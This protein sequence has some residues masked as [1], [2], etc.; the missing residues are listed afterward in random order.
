M[1]VSDHIFDPETSSVS[2]LTR[3]AGDLLSLAYRR[4]DP[5]EIFNQSSAWRVALDQKGKASSADMHFIGLLGE[6]AAAVFLG[7]A[8]V[9]EEI[10]GGDGGRGDL[11]L[12][13]GKMVQVKTRAWQG[14]DFALG[15]ESPA[16]FQADYGI[17]VWPGSQEVAQAMRHCGD[18]TA[19]ALLTL[20]LRSELILSIAGVITREDF[21]SRFQ[22]K[23]LGYGTRAVV[24]WHDMQRPEDWL[25]EE[26]RLVARG[27]NVTA[28]R[29]QARVLTWRPR[30]D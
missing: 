11:T 26:C 2:I 3:K 27:T 5:K 16:E 25:R 12:P 7:L 10:N 17:L 29:P 6:Y 13:N 21:L 8:G 15:G 19:E 14:W 24:E 30:L 22:R 1:A 4:N 28:S 20:S 18:A 9:D 23:Y